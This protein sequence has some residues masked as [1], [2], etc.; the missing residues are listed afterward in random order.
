VCDVVLQISE[1]GGESEEGVGGEEDLVFDKNCCTDRVERTQRTLLRVFKPLKPGVVAVTK[2]LL[3]LLYTAY[4]L[5]CLCRPGGFG[6]TD[7]YIL[8]VVTLVSYI[9][10]VIKCVPARLWPS[11]LRLSSCTVSYGSARCQKIR[12]WSRW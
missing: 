2:W 12:S 11:Q 1:T 9:V 4:F 10:M 3:L 7:S 8:L 5:Y 6:D